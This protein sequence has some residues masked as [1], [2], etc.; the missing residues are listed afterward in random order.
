MDR[1]F[2]D[3]DRSIWDLQQNVRDFCRNAWL[4]DQNVWDSKYLRILTKFS[5][6]ST[7]INEDIAP[8]LLQEIFENLD[9][10]PE[11]P[12]NSLRFLLISLK[13]WVH[14]HLL[15]SCNLWGLEVWGSSGL[16]GLSANSGGAI[17]WHRMSMMK[18][19]EGTW[20]TDSVHVVDFSRCARKTKG[21]NYNTLEQN[22]LFELM[23]VINYPAGRN[24]IMKRKASVL[25]NYLLQ[26]K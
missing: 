18:E 15:N 9:R 22:N 11:N 6:S 12:N 21:S 16:S 19:G 23:K 24:T 17:L 14:V 5:M 26:S 1:Y 25:F 13:F 20:F 7:E 2:W 10:N 8:R 4:F 3:F